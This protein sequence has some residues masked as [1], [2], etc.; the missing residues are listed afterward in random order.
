MALVAPRSYRRGNTESVINPTPAQLHELHHPPLRLFTRLN[1]PLRSSQRRVTSQELNVSQRPT[2]RTDFPRPSRNGCP[3]PTMGRGSH[4]SQRTVPTRELVHDCIGACARRT[5][6][7]D[8]VRASALR[9]V[10]SSSPS[11]GAWPTHQGKPNTGNEVRA[12]QNL[13]ATSEQRKKAVHEW[14]SY[15]RAFCQGSG[16]GFESLRPLQSRRLLHE[17]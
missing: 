13:G 12:G 17:L 2:Y 5:L 14:R 7:R 15:G 11:P 10:K 8:H 1:V 6:G 16:R 3:P 9:N 4:K